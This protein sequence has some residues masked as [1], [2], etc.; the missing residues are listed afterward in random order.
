[1]DLH[2]IVR[3][4]SNMPSLIEVLVNLVKIRLTRLEFFLNRHSLLQVLPFSMVWVNTIY[5]RT[6][7]CSIPYEYSIYLFN[8]VD[9]TSPQFAL[10]FRRKTNFTKSCILSCTHYSTF[11]YRIAKKVKTFTAFYLKLNKLINVG[12]YLKGYLRI[13]KNMEPS[14]D[15]NAFGKVP[16]MMHWYHLDCFVEM[17]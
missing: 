14:P 13:G 16:L 12:V 6:V 10:F 17:R 7:N 3:L 15:S 11:L 2:K 1:M 8:N 4:G 5:F 9:C